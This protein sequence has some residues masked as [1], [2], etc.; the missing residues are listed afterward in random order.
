MRKTHHFLTASK[1]GSWCS[2]KVKNKVKL[3][4]IN[5][6]QRRESRIYKIVSIR[7][8]YRYSTNLV[9]KQDS[10]VLQI[11]DLG[12]FQLNKSIK[13]DSCKNTPSLHNTH[14]KLLWL[15]PPKSKWMVKSKSSIKTKQ[16]HSAQSWDCSKED[17][18]SQN[19]FNRVEVDQQVGHTARTI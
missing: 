15:L 14:Y 17:K 16:T 8:L 6:Q 5:Q 4:T 7:S 11:E 10:L 19:P 2:I 13:A 12:H 9:I 1:L 3:Y 18:L